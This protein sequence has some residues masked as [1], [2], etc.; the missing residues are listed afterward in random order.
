MSSRNIFSDF[1]S[2]SNSSESSERN[3]E[4]FDI[5]RRSK[6]AK[7]QK[8]ILESQPFEDELYYRKTKKSSKTSFYSKSNDNSSPEE[9]ST[10]QSLAEDD[11]SD[12]DFFG[13]LMASKNLSPE[14]EISRKSMKRV[15]SLSPDRY[16]SELSYQDDEKS[17]FQEAKQEWGKISQV[18]SLYSIDG[19]YL[20]E[21]EIIKR[22]LENLSKFPLDKL[23][24]VDGRFFDGECRLT[25]PYLNLCA[26]ANKSPVQYY[27]DNHIKKPKTKT[28]TKQV[29]ASGNNSKVTGDTDIDIAEVKEMLQNLSLKEV[30]ITKSGTFDKKDNTTCLY[31]DLC[32]IARKDPV[33]FYT[34]KYSA[35]EQ[36]VGFHEKRSKKET[37]LR[38]FDSNSSESI[39]KNAS[40]SASALKELK[41][42]PLENLKTTKD[43][44]FD[45]RSNLTQAYLDLCAK[46]RENPLKYYN[47]H[48]DQNDFD[49]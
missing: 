36:N 41:K 30:K 26:Q 13:E 8:N 19:E 29:K 43:G 15:Q 49:I 32:K 4:S 7:G 22:A 39:G 40:T 11:Y 37:S 12:D 27:R 9:R 46:A 28:S 47:K 38:K 21:R 3:K 2:R 48:Y 44:F 6:K 34:K 25:L 5:S 14:K 23:N 16:S 10:K 20:S 17:D 24:I 18:E 42:F 33:K 45:K 35:K 31:L 1:D